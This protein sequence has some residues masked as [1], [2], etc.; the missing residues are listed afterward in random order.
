MVGNMPTSCCV[1]GCSNRHS[2]SSDLHFYRFPRDPD[3]R[4]MWLSFI[5]RRNQDGTPWEPGDGD[6]V[7]SQHFLSGS[8][9]NVPTDPDYVPSVNPGKENVVSPGCSSS[10]ARFQR[11]QRR[12]RATL[13]KKVGVEAME[14]QRKLLLTAVQHDHGTLA[15]PGSEYCDERLTVKAPGHCELMEVSERD[16]IISVDIGMC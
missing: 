16:K 10:V 4:R 6:R 5:C 3:R 11:A 8:K 13:V 14:Q 9:S 15:K 2:S 12:S 7:C 1:I